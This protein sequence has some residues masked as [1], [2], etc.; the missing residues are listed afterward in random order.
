VVLDAYC[1][2][3]TTLVAAQRAGRAWIGIDLAPQAVALTLERI[4]S[5]FGDEAAERIAVCGARQDGIAEATRHKTPAPG[6]VIL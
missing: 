2:C 5:T 1:G 6:V 4:K 3:G